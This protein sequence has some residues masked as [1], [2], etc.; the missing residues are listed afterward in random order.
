LAAPQELPVPREASEAAVS[1]VL[2]AQVWVFPHRKPRLAEPAVKVVLAAAGQQV[3][4]VVPAR[5]P[6]VFQ[7]SGYLFLQPRL[8]S[9][10]DWQE[11][12]GTR[13]KN[14]KF[15]HIAYAVSTGHLFPVLRLTHR[16]LRL[17]RRLLEASRLRLNKLARSMR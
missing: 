5:A 17:S 13:Y 12:A 11:R 10:L 3:S 1:R 4:E 14:R 6:P 8:Y 16:F 2:A 7:Y 9:I 15:N